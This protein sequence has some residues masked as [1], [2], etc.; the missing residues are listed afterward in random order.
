MTFA[1]FNGPCPV[2]HRDGDIST[3]NYMNYLQ[4]IINQM[5]ERIV[6]LEAQNK[7]LLLQGISDFGQYQE[8]SAEREQLLTRIAELEK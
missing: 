1:A 7:E 3:F 8:W 6:S 5:H 4:S 2:C